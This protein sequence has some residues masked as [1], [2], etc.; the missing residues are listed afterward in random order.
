MKKLLIISALSL[1]AV[2]SF[3]QGLGKG[4]L[5]G[6]HMLTINL[7][8]GVTIDQFKDFYVTKVIPEFEKNFPEAK[9][10]LVKSIR[11]ELN[12]TFGVLWVFPSE[13]ARD[14][15]FDKE[16][17]NDTGKAADARTQPI[18]KELEKLGTSTSKYVDWVVQ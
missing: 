16:E 13:A 14:K 5:V 3:G 9:G 4:N 12:N 2:L 11:G 17:L 6:V 10:Y 8:P 7:K 15:Y 18:L 1:L